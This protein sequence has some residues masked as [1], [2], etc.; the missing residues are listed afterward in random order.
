MNGKPAYGCYDH[1]FHKE[2]FI[3]GWCVKIVA[4]EQDRWHVDDQSKQDWDDD[5]R[6]QFVHLGEDVQKL[7]ENQGSESDAHNVHKRIV[8]E[9]Y[10]WEH[11]HCSLVDWDPDPNKEGLEV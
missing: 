3:D 10:T 8:E 7:N 5:F 6:L 4:E 2:L 9:N 11:N 1:H